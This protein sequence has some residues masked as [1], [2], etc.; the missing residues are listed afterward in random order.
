MAKAGRFYAAGSCNPSARAPVSA[1]SVEHMDMERMEPA[2]ADPPPRA[3]P[4]GGAAPSAVAG[5]ARPLVWL[6]AGLGSGTG[7]GLAA[8]DGDARAAGAASVLLAAAVLLAARRGL[9]PVWTAWVLVLAFARASA[10]ARPPAGAHAA[11]ALESAELRAAPIAGRWRAGRDGRTGWIEP[12]AGEARAPGHALLF[13]PDGCAPRDGEALALLPGG[14]VVPWS[15]GPEPAPRTRSERFAAHSSVAPDELVRLAPGPNTPWAA[16]A[17]ELADLRVALGERA[18][19]VEGAESTGLLRALA[20]GARE[21]LPQERIDLFARTGTSHLLA[22]SGWHVGLFAA[23]VVLPLARAAP[24]T[25]RRWTALA[26]RTA[27]LFLFAG[28]AGAEKPVLRA[29]LALVFLQLAWLRPRAARALPL[30]PDGLSS[31]AGAF[32][33][34]CLLDP[35]GLDSLSLALSYAATLGLIAGTGPIAGA[36]RP[37]RERW[38]GLGDG[39]LA[40]AARI[41][42]A[43]LAAL[44]ASGLAASLAAVLATLPLTWATFGEFAPAG[45]L[46]TVLSMP[47]FTFLSV[48]AWLAALVPWSGF[49]AP[50]ELGAR[51]LYA[52]LELG[53][54]LPWTPLVLPPRPLALLV[55][56]TV[57]AFLGL[58]HAGA[59]RAAALVFGALLLPWSAAPR[60]LEL[61]A[62]DV[63]HGSALV[64][65]APGLDALVFD[66]G[67][68]DRRAVASEALVPLLARREVARV[69]VVLSHPDRDHS[70][71]LGRLAERYPIDTWLGAAPAQGL[72]RWPHGL[73]RLDLGPGRLA[74]GRPCPELELALL[75]GSGNEGN[76]GSRALEV[77]W[78]GQ[79]LVLLGDAE[80]EG[81]AGLPLAPGP[82]RLLL[83]P[84]HGSDG[85]ALWDLL[86]RAPPAEVWVS[87]A[88]RPA[89]A[90]ELERR[91]L[92]WRWTGRDGP[93][94]LH[95][96]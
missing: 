34:E 56:A 4:S 74:C 14:E 24:R 7:L 47:A 21:E 52:V 77:A 50:A 89:I 41:L 75:R 85:P 3:P 1:P 17:G 22:I 5:P 30:R 9:A 55:F 36:L 62:L 60:G 44:F 64:L 69:R 48:L 15:R 63:G 20:I 65:R 51:A 61:S 72:V 92:P 26:A 37:E 58:R 38:S 42:G 78:R 12:F 28:V 80:E 45:A 23:L 2:Q 66:A 18:A 25:R 73:E 19:R 57:L 43:R 6:A 59:R 70:S 76:E 10:L 29:T 32:A 91:A 54:A 88:A 35:G 46:L 16:L 68:R 53:D 67:S 83:A 40:R 95:L 49:R 87:S 8:A 94:A 27:L 82:L 81:L 33:L 96:P 39:R 71:G 11:T 84:H 13:E 86:E 31:L 93:L 79:R 90:A